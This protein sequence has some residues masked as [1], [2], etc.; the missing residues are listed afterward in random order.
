MEEPPLFPVLIIGREIVGTGTSRYVSFRLSLPPNLHHQSPDGENIDYVNTRYS[1]VEGLRTALLQ[2]FPSL[3]LPMLDSKRLMGSLSSSVVNQ[4]TRII[5]NFLRTCQES[6]TI[7]SSRQWGEFLRGQKPG[8][9]TGDRQA[10]PTASELRSE[11][12]TDAAPPPGLSENPAAVRGMSFGWLLENMNFFN[13]E[14]APAAAPPEYTME[15]GIAPPATPEITRETISNTVDSDDEDDMENVA[16]NSVAI[17]TPRQVMRQEFYRMVQESRGRTT[18]QTHRN[19]FSGTAEELEKGETTSAI[20]IKSLPPL[21]FE[22]IGCFLLGLVVQFTRSGPTKAVLDSKSNTTPMLLNFSFTVAALMY[23]L[24]HVSGGHMNPAVTF[25]VFLRRHLTFGQMSAYI[26]SQFFGFLLSAVVG[27]EVLGEILVPS[28]V[29]TM[30]GAGGL[31]QL[32]CFALVAIFTFGVT[33]TVL[34]TCTSTA[35][36]GNS[37]F[38]LGSGFSLGIGMVANA[39][40]G[41]GSTLNSCLDVALVCAKWFYD[42]DFPEPSDFEGYMKF[43]N[44]GDNNMWYLIAGPAAGALLSTVVWRYVKVTAFTKR[45]HG[46]CNKILKTIA[47]YLVECFGTFMVAFTWLVFYPASAAAL[48]NQAV[49][50]MGMTFAVVYAGGFISGGHFNPA[51]S[52]GVALQGK[53]GVLNLFL[54]VFWQCAGA[55][56]AGA[57]NYEIFASSPVPAVGSEVSE[58]NAGIVEGLFSFMLVFVML[59]CGSARANKGNSFYGMANGFVLYVATGAIGTMTGGALNPA[60]GFGAFFSRWMFNCESCTDSWTDFDM[61]GFDGCW[62]SMAVPLAGALVA[63]IVFHA[64]VEGYPLPKFCKCEGKKKGA[65]GEDYD[66]MDRVSSLPPGG[67]SESSAPV[68]EMVDM[69]PSTPT[70]S[71]AIERRAN[72]RGGTP[73][74]LERGPTT[75]I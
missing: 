74:T 66:T 18:S 2:E 17:V 48:Q 10:P 62:V 15:E 72:E 12:R 53:M 61:V 69:A 41:T 23:A 8:V 9:T 51:I 30:T 13:D 56:G 19:L 44:N 38:G 27:F 24:G 60:I 68:A 54:Y 22:F 70:R 25:A 31:D 35:Q 46:L 14:Q 29:K 71:P 33:Y 21:V 16:A 32:K 40:A 75:S 39:V 49:A 47:P 3:D 63:G 34:C 5:N 67:G 59:N 45:S 50:Y 58:Q 65:N 64:C 1:Y 20:L 36:T 4:R 55:F 42:S 57:V 43:I 7:K 26:C 37:H 11:A 73:R 28:E 52:F 6:N